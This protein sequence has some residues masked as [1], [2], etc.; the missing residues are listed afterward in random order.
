MVSSCL[1][2]DCAATD[3]AIQVLILLQS[4]LLSLLLLLPQ[5][6]YC[7]CCC[8]C[9]YCGFVSAAITLPRIAAAA[10]TTEPQYS[11]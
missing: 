3:A 2:A 6:C 7:C 9:Y 5:Y 11:R 1:Y 4:L 10:T 8:H